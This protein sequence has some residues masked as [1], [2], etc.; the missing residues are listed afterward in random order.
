MSRRNETNRL[1]HK[2]KEDQKK[3][4][5]K[6]AELER[7]QKIK[8]ITRKYNESQNNSRQEQV[9]VLFIGNYVKLKEFNIIF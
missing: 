1:N 3:R 2:K 4:K 5:I 9:N 7:K 8:E 6:D